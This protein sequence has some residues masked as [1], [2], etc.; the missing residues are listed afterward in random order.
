MAIFDG[1]IPYT[2]LHELNLD[3]VIRKLKEVIK[4]VENLSDDLNEELEQKIL[5]YLNEHLSEIMLMATYVEE[6]RTLK[7][8]GGV[9]NG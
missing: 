5:E 4:E 6:T 8:T 3:W 7:I 9:N 1:N 2:N